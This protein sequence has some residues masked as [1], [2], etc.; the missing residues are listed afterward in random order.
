MP[1]TFS[2][3]NGFRISTGSIC[4]PL[5]GTWA[6][7]VKVITPETITNPVTLSFGNLT[8]MGHVYRSG[9]FSGI[10]Y[11]R[12]VGGAGGWRQTVQ[13]QAYSNPNNVKLSTVLGD[14]A[15]AVG[16]QVNVVTDTT[17]GS[18]YIRENAPAE[19]LLRQ[20]AGPLWWMNPAGVTQIGPRSSSA[21]STAFLVETWDAGTNK[22]LISTEDYASWMPGNTFTAPTVPNSQTISMTYLGVDDKGTLRL[23]VLGSP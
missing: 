23:T 14:A 3:C 6:G 5:Y 21:I 16:E 11:V 10:Q 7:D 22:F 17:L 4:I 2:T 1:D 18:F 8:L 12:L 19:R 13:A 9:A 20:L 15:A